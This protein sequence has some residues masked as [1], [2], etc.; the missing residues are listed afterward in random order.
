MTTEIISFNQD[1]NRKSNQ[2][3]RAGQDKWCVTS[4]GDKQVT[5]R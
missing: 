2:L 1:R 3:L 4:V 5:R